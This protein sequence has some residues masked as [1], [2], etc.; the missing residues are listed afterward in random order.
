MVSD[1]VLYNN[2]D[3]AAT[4]DL[5]FL[6]TG[7]DN[8]G[9]EAIRIKLP[10]HTATRMVDFVRTVFGKDLASGALLIASDKELVV[11]SRR[12]SRHC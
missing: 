11:G 5:W 2:E 3:G 4:V 1:A 6:E 9:D 10:E 8:S 12:Q 7:H